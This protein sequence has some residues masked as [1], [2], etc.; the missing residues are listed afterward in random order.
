MEMAEGVERL[1]SAATFKRSAPARV[2]RHGRTVEFF[3]LMTMTKEE[4]F[5]GDVKSPCTAP[6]SSGTG[7]SGHQA[8]RYVHMAPDPTSSPTKPDCTAP[9]RPPRLG[10]RALPPGDGGRRRRH[11][12]LPYTTAY[13]IINGQSLPVS[14]QQTLAYL[15]ACHLDPAEVRRWIT[16]F[17]RIE[18]LETSPVLLENHLE[19]NGLRCGSKSVRCVILT[20]INSPGVN[21]V[22]SLLSTSGWCGFDA[23]GCIPGIVLAGCQMLRSAGEVTGSWS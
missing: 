8:P 12:E 2:F 20:S 19:Q 6:R 23:T 13:R 15:L 7:A 11:G 17:I 5:N 14:R 18:F 10:R 3:V 1:P 22:R 4:A 21:S 16:A 9:A